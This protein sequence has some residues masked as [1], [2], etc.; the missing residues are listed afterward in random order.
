MTR[1]V[2][3]NIL[4]GGYN[5]QEQGA[6]RTQQ[7]TQIIRSAQPDIVGVIE[8]IHP[9][10][11]QKPLVVEEIAEA[12]DMRL[13]TTGNGSFA[14]DYQLA[15]L[16]H[17]PVVHTRLH[18]RPGCLNKPLLEVCV[19]ER[20][21]QHLTIFVTHLSASFNR[22]WAGSHLRNREVREILRILA[23]LRAEGTP[24]VLI[25]DF[26][27]L[28]PGD[29]F[30]ASFL[31]RYVVNLDQSEHDPNVSDGNPYLHL[32]VPK[33]LRFL[34]PLL[35]L[36]PRSKILSTLFDTAATL[37][38]PRHC[39]RLL[40]QAQYVD[41]YRQKHPHEW[42]FTCPA[43]SPAGR[44]DFIFASPPTLVQRLEE[45][46]VITHTQGLLGSQ[47]SDHLALSAAFTTHVNSEENVQEDQEV[48][49]N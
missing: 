3:Y 32:V 26:N 11:Q 15:L 2:S 39:I 27:S 42:G 10:M 49:A 33:Q 5:L 8:A 28:A 34:H 6:R 24:H 43:A 16:T 45:C 48:V 7:L 46:T 44:I 14:N 13:I 38:A 4:A 19:E 37:Y 29:P 1:I 36:I 17:L 18:K 12:L 22:G 25:G 21:G 31:V 35:R 30:K 40:L 9:Q 23:P 47:A 20:D 41:C